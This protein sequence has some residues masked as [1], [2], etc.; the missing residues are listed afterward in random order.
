M[1]KRDMLFAWLFLRRPRW[2]GIGTRDQSLFIGKEF[3]AIAGCFDQGAVKRWGWRPVNGLWEPETFASSKEA[4]AAAEA[5]A[6]KRTPRRRR[7]FC[8]TGKG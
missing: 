1:G 2:R 6:R 8:F 5:W 4:R 7:F 3:M